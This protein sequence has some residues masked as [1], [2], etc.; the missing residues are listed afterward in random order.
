MLKH[1]CNVG[2]FLLLMTLLLGVAY[3]LAVTAIGGTLF[4]DQAAGSLVVRDGR[5][6]GSSL[7]EQK[8]GRPGYFHP[9]PSAAGSDGY[10]ATSSGGSNLGVATRSLDDA[11]AER[12]KAARHDDAPVPADLVMASGSGLDP[13][14]SPE[15]ARYQIQRVAAAR[16]LPPAEVEQLVNAHVE[17]RQLGVFGEPRV[18]VLALNLALDDYARTGSR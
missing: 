14:V 18:N 10:D 5:V 8:F 3:P 15:A 7:I 17:G 9:R 12:A 16:G 4:P 13:H 2:A 11:I 6:V 1:T